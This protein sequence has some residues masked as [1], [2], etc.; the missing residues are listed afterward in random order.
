MISDD[1]KRQ[2]REICARYPSA[3][4]GTLPCLHLAQEVEGYITAEGIAAVAEVTGTKVDEVQSVV[5]FYSMYF[6]EPPGQYVLKVCTSISCYLGGCDALLR[7]LEHRLA[8]KRGETRADGKYTLMGVECLAACGMAPVLQVNGEFVENL[9]L[10]RADELVAHLEAGEPVRSGPGAWNVL[11]ATPSGAS[12]AERAA[13]ADRAT[14]G[15]EGTGASGGRLP[16]D[17]RSDGQRE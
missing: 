16:P 3:R 9:S 17:E 2:M 8:V 1:V 13:G 10:E 12:I 11:A 7:H 14:A 15:G 5:T 6:R 4:S